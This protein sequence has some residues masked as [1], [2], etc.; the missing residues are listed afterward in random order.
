M[1]VSEV[2]PHFGKQIFESFCNQKTSSCSDVLPEF[3][4][5]YLLLIIVQPMNLKLD[6]L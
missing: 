3:K 1:P 5:A 2:F 6:G 4:L